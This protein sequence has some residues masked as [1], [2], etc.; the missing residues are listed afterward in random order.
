M[1]GGVSCGSTLQARRLEMSEI[2]DGAESV[3]ELVEAGSQLTVGEL[4]MQ[5]CE[6]RGLRVDEAARR[7]YLLWEEGRIRLEDPEPPRSVLGYMSSLYSLWLWMLVS[8]VALTTLSIYLLPQRPP[9]IYLRYAAG[10]LSVLYLP[11]AAFIEALYPGKEDLEPLER[12]ALSIGL[13]LALVPLVGLVLNYTPWGIR[14]N[15][16]YA[17]LSLLT[18]T[19]AVLSVCRKFRHFARIAKAEVRADLQDP[20]Q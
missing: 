17:F 5:L 19:L 8:V 6:G 16:V 2:A 10:A 13:S 14:L 20:L 1:G 12:L 18:L 9:Y 4:V 15:P 7:V 11:G 3:L